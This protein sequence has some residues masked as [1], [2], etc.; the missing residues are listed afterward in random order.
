[1]L[2]QQ[3]ICFSGSELFSKERNMH[4]V[5]LIRRRF[6]EQ[7]NSV[8]GVLVFLSASAL[9]IGIGILLLMK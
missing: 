2:A 5:K 6:P 8:I 9:L 7:S 4:I 3:G 1:M